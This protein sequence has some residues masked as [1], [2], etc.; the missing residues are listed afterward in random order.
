MAV[1]LFQTLPS[2]SI[3]TLDLSTPS[4][5]EGLGNEGSL[6]F[7]QY[8]RGSKVLTVL[9]VDQFRLTEEAFKGITFTKDS[10]LKKLSLNNNYEV[11]K[12]WTELFNGLCSS[13]TVAYH[14]QWRI[15]WGALGA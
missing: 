5:S 14:A 2:T 13:C 15:Q 9:R 10:P 4:N 11:K 1:L 3:T 6:A 12:G 7:K 8:I